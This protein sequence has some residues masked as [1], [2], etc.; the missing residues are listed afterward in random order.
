MHVLMSVG[1]LLRIIVV[2]VIGTAL[3]VV[4]AFGGGGRDAESD[5]LGS[6]PSTCVAR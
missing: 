4:M 2:I 3:L 5:S 6:V 1:A